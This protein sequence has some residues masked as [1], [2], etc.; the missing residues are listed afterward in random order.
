M[1]REKTFRDAIREHGDKLYR[2]CCCHILDAEERKD[3]YQETLV[4]IWKGLSGFREGAQL[5]TWA[6]RIAVN[7]CLDHLRK[8]GRRKRIL[9]TRLVAEEGDPL[10]GIPAAVPLPPD[11]RVS[12]LYACVD[13]LPPAERTIVSLY[14]EDLSGAEIAGITELSEVS[15]RVRVHRAKGLLRSM[16][17]GAEYGNR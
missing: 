8:T 4:H 16:M 14:L 2:I 15:V 5:S 13:R 3:A 10:D 17:N 6:T 1:D 9:G 12:R 7:T 11:E